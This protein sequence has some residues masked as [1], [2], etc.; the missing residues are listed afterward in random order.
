MK[1]L[2]VPLKIPP[3]SFVYSYLVNKM[4]YDYITVVAIFKIRPDGLNLS[5]V[6]KL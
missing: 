4:K 3:T 5:S 1:Y 2:G 6:E